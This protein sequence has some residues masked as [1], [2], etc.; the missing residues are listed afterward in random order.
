VA[1]LA[2]ELLARL[3]T[4][5]VWRLGL[6]AVPEI[7]QQMEFTKLAGFPTMTKEILLL[8]PEAYPAPIF[9]RDGGNV[10]WTTF[11]ALPKEAFRSAPAQEEARAGVVRIAFF[12]GSTTWNGYPEEVGKRL[13][14]RFGEGRVEVLNLGVPS[15]TSWTSL[16]VMRNYL[17]RWR[18]HLAVVYQGFNDQ[19]AGAARARALLTEVNGADLV[20]APSPSRGLFALARA[21]FAQPTRTRF[22]DLLEEG[23]YGRPEDAWWSMARLAWAEGVTLV[24]STFAAPD[25]AAIPHAERAF[26]EA[27]FRYAFP[28]VG[29]LEVYAARLA[30]ENARVRAFAEAAGLAVIDVAAAVR[31]GREIFKDNCHLNE[32]GRYRQSEVVAAVLAEPVRQLLD[33]G[34]TPPTPRLAAAA[35]RGLVGQPADGCGR[36]RC[37]AGSCLVE[38]GRAPLGYAQTDQYRFGDA[39]RADLGLPRDWYADPRAT[40]EWEHGAFCLDRDERSRADRAACVAAAVCPPYVEAPDADLP[41]SLPTAA[42]AGALCAF[43][44]GRLPDE[45][46]WEAGAR[47]DDGRLLP[48]GDRWSGAEANLCGRECPLGQSSSPDDGVVGPS[49]RGHFIGASPSGLRDMAGNL[50]EWVVSC[51][52]ESCTEWLRGGSALS[53]P[54]LLWR[55]QADGLGD[56]APRLRGVRCAYDASP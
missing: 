28:W 44:G 9:P 30:A 40:G 49:A 46:E 12:G 11:A 51:T 17:R 7:A 29:G 19:V 24:F 33:G 4:L 38:P 14:E 35:D 16:V 31:G 6:A 55:R 48:W 36:G 37:P 18:P 26:F 54:G 15:G 47:G 23:L 21:A 56:T 2:G 1:I 20:L 39:L 34:A 52:K 3:A 13:A 22:H 43:F 10:R 25:Y 5:A 45:R 32:S 8:S 42:E 50:A 53:P 27:E 41:A